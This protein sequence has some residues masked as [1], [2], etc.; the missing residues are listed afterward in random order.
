LDVMIGI[1][2]GLAYLHER[3]YCHFDIKGGN[4]L[5]HE[6][7]GRLSAVLAD[8]GSARKANSAGHYSVTKPM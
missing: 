1:F 7:G 2:S 3:G 5:V 4:V 8:M 6:E